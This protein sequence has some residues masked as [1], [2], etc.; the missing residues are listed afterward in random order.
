MPSYFPSGILWRFAKNVA[1]TRNICQGFTPPGLL[2]QPGSECEVAGQFGRRFVL[3]R[4]CSAAQVSNLVA[5]RLCSAASE[6]LN[7]HQHCSEQQHRCSIINAALPF[8]F[9]PRIEICAGN[10]VLSLAVCCVCL[11]GG[12]GRG[13]ESAGRAV[14]SSCNRVA[15]AA[16]SRSGTGQLPTSDGCASSRVAVVKLRLAMDLQQLLASSSIRGP[17]MHHHST[18]Q[19]DI[20]E[21]LLLLRHSTGVLHSHQACVHGQKRSQRHFSPEPEPATCM[22]METATNAVQPSAPAQTSARLQLDYVPFKA[23]YTAITA[24][25]STTSVPFG[26]SLKHISFQRVV[27]N[28]ARTTWQGRASLLVT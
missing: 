3:T 25:P 1:Q 18:Q 26:C 21:E 24:T 2:C 4:L 6:V 19:Y 15:A 17:Q 13:D 5:R 27:Q 16:A 9:P 8:S 10:A 12:G 20:A 7:Q 22:P 23:W 28:V 14:R 11:W